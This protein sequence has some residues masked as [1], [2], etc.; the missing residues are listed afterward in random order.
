MKH[1][2]T[3]LL[4]LS[5]ASIFTISLAQSTVGPLVNGTRVCTLECRTERPDC[6]AGE[7]PMGSEGCWGCCQPINPVTV[8][9]ATTST[10]TSTTP[11]GACAQDCHSDPP[12]CQAGWQPQGIEGCWSQ[13]CTQ[14]SSTQ[15]GLGTGP[16]SGTTN[17]SNSTTTSTTTTT[18]AVTSPTTSNT[19]TGT[20]PGSQNTGG[21]IQFKAAGGAILALHSL[22]IGFWAL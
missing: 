3:S 13:C 18:A 6:P 10:S 20:A 16:T 14:G 9:T 11:G 12:R 19:Q 21:S 4:L 17:P 15:T 8:K 22:L 2:S 1:T 7:A 5:I